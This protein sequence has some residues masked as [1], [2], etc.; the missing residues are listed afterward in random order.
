MG[1]SSCEYR[2][3]E[4]GDQEWDALVTAGDDASLLQTWAYGEAKAETGPWRVER[5]V[6]MA[7]G[8]VVAAAQVLIRD[9]PLPGSGM[10][11]INRGPVGATGDTEAC[12][13]ALL[14]EFC[15]QRGYYLRTQPPCGDDDLVLP[16]RFSRTS[17][18]G[19][20]SSVVDLREPEEV[21]RKNLHRKWR[22]HLSRA[23]RSNLELIVGT[24]KTIFD[25]F[26]EGH[27]AHLAR[28]GP[29]GG[30]DPALL[31]RLQER[32]AP[33]QKL[34]CFITRKDGSYLGGAAIAR[35]G[36]TGEYLAGHNTQAGRA[37][38]A[39]QLL[40]WSAMLRLKADG[41]TRLDLGGM[42]EHLTTPG[43]FEFKQRIGGMPYR[44]ANELEA[45]ATGIVNRLI[46]WRVRRERARQT[47]QAGGAP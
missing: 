28:L 36:A 40:L 10:A 33:E 38:K 45:G 21:L 6:V 12:L 16:A 19:W 4:G 7:G 30:L 43:I 23:E 15:D 46:R 17:T 22:N 11:W 39:G 25:A 41:Y 31:H 34:L 18:P 47:E 27:A 32:L 26:M 8:E 44:L 24:G 37:N 9:A 1:G 2:V 42:D 35:I 13:G 5:G 3:F 29:A 20:A 14:R